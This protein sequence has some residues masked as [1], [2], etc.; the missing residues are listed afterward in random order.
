MILFKVYVSRFYNQPESSSLIKA[1][2]SQL[3]IIKDRIFT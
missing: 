2:Q 1:N 3:G